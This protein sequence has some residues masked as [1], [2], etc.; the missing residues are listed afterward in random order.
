[1]QEMNYYLMHQDDIVCSVTI[2]RATGAMIRV[3]AP[4]APELLPPGGNLDADTLRKWW[5]RRAVPA[6]QGNIGHILDQLGIASPQEY[7]VKNLGL[8]LIDHYWLKP[9]DMPLRWNDVN[10]FCN[11]FRDPVGD[12]QVGDIEA[13]TLQP[14]GC[15]SPSSSLQGELNKK[16]LII[17]GKRYLL[18]GNHGGNS[19]ES[20]NEVFASLLH[21][22]QG[23]FPY[24]D[25]KCVMREP[26]G[27]FFCICECFT[28]DQVEFIPAIDVVNSMKK[29]NAISQYE[30][31]IEVAV[32]NGM[33]E[34]EV[35][36]FLEYQ[37]L[38]DYIISNTDRHLGNFGVLRDGKTLQYIGMAPIFD[39][40]NSMFWNQP[41]LPCHSDLK[42]IRVNSFRS[43][44]HQLLELVSN[45]DAIQFSHLPS[46]EE[47][48]LIYRQDPMIA[49]PDAIAL[50]YKKKIKMLESFAE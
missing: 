6:S 16:W 17:Q 24:V 3:S 44:E 1:M 49:R 22:K 12:M 45:K 28:S 40:G 9:I 21:R 33:T 35:R 5:H 14:D 34:S 30:H 18:K 25:Y 38:T 27:Q 31:F 50:G 10:L 2:D 39:S 46:E 8:S 41:L 48:Y 13:P 29:D 4:L 43:K 11:E 20:L 15:Y 36:A 42:D 19:Q 47:L 37:I 26:Q 7:L 23:L 32:G